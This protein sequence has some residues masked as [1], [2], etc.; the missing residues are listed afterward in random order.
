VRP[1]QCLRK[2]RDDFA[3]QQLSDVE[4]VGV[5]SVIVDTAVYAG[6]SGVICEVAPSLEQK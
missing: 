3:T 5:G 6:H 4:R 2:V 1:T